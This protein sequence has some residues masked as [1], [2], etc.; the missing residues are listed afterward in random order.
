[1]GITN[2]AFPFPKSKVRYLCPYLE[3]HRLRCLFVTVAILTSSYKIVLFYYNTHRK[4]LQYI[5]RFFSCGIW[6]SNIFTGDYTVMCLFPDTTNQTAGAAYG[7]YCISH[8]T[9]AIKC[10]LILLS[11][12]AFFIFFA[13]ATWTRV[14][15]SH[16]QRR[17]FQMCLCFQLRCIFQRS[18]S[19]VY[20]HTCVI[21]YFHQQL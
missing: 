6:F 17:M 18:I 7:T 21:G 12:A 20:P 9:C 13:A 14:I 2:N 15:S 4:R 11:T 1:M 5:F 16:F 8:S 10:T 3:Y 19:T